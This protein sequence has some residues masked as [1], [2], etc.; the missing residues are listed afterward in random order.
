MRRHLIHFLLVA[1]LTVCSV[2]TAF[3]QTTVKGQVVDAETGDPLIG[4]AV[5]VAGTTQGSVTDLDGYFTQRVGQNETLVIKY[6][7]YKDF[8]KKITQVGSADLG[9]IKLEADA[10]VLGDVTITSSI[11][12]ARKTPVA[13]STIDPVFIEEKLGTQEFPEILKSTPGVYATKDNGG[14]GEARINLRG[15]EAANIAVM[16][17][18]VP[19]N[20]ME[21][22]GIYWSNW[23]GLSDV[24]RSMQVQRGL[25]ASKI[26]AP[27]VGGSI[28]IV[29]RTTDA[30][31]GGSVSYGIGND[32]YNKLAFSVSTGMNNKGW[33]FSI[34]GSKT[35]GD[36]YIKGAEFSAYSWFVNVSKKLGDSHSLSLTATGA[37]QTHNKR[38]DKLTIEEWAKQKEYGTRYNAVYGFDINGKLRT[39]SSYNYYHKPQISLNHQ[40]NIDSKSSLSSSLYMSIGKGG[41]YSAQGNNSAWFYGATNGIPNTLY[42]KID[43]TFDYPSLMEANAASANGSL[44]AMSSSVNEHMW[45]GLVST[46]TRELRE[47]LELQAGIDLR[48]YKGVHTN[49]L[50]DLYGGDFYIDSYYR[51][52]VEG[53]AN[54]LAFQNQ[55]L[56]IG[57]VVKRDYDGFVAQ[58]GGFAQLE[59]S[60]DKL[61]V[62][63]SGN[64]N[65]NAFWRYDRFYYAP[66]NER[67]ETVTKVGFGLKGGANY[68]ITEHH[69]VFANVGYYSRTPFFSS[70]FL[71]KDTSN[72][73]NKDC[74]NEKVFSFELGYGFVS[75]K[76]SANLNLYRTA[77]NDRTM[78][79]PVSDAQ[80]SAYINMQ[81]VN[82]LHQGIELDFRAQP[83]RG[84]E[85]TGMV[86]IGDWN[87]NS[88]AT[89]YWYNRYGEALDAQKQVV[90]PGSP[91]HAK[92]NMNLKGIKVGNS[93]QTTAALGVSYELIKGLR[94]SIDGNYYGRNYANYDISM[95]KTTGD[96]NFQ[97]PWKIPNAFVFDGHVSYRFKLGNIDASW[98]A[99]VSNLFNEQYITDAQDNGAKTAKEGE[100]T[101]WKDATVF[102]G[103]GRT[104]STSLKFRF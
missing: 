10:V 41:G 64:I 84:L 31:K 97:D 22:G 30:K 40:W 18:G 6:L 36:G 62:F 71:S 1:I 80:E 57:D 90:E 95:T 46:Y 35:W 33:A 75:S 47:G 94:F 101:T 26:S 21:W 53:R 78:V 61:S 74:L 34:L 99:S 37:P 28:N 70:V 19:V 102:Y 2:A 17:N 29:T 12:V 5:T 91:E 82:A 72:N 38:Y 24:T 79:K 96:N 11:A 9:V 59:Y 63:A 76:F 67:S 66:G 92:V 60:I 48:Y 39:G 77:W 27:A 13:V 4:A 23:S 89:G 15:F 14:Y 51:K 42:R 85:I 56:Q 54:D 68:N 86:S 88:N 87:W 32:G 69:N 45:Y 103:F 52:N 50:V 44:A 55:K 104:W 8:K 25:G 83:L 49:E 81:G 3:A 100:R 98:N 73:T 43:G 20:D 7:G 65:S 58:Y 93:A 16:V